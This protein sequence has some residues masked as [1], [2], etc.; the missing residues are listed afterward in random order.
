[1]VQKRFFRLKELDINYNQSIHDI[2]NRLNNN[3]RKQKRKI[4]MNMKH[5]QS[6]K[7]LLYWY[8]V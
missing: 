6:E 8:G 7:N 3:C 2:V 4:K 5:Y 1:M